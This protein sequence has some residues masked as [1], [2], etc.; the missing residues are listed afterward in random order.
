[1][2]V[3]IRGGIGYKEKIYLFIIG[4]FNNDFIN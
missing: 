4:S 1:M 2:K 3:K